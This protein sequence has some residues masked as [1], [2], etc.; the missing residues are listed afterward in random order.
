MARGRTLGFK[1]GGGWK[2][3][4]K[5]TVGIEIDVGLQIV[6]LVP[7]EDDSFEPQEER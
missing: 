6:V 5:G 3:Q 7:N 4:D 1:I 2:S